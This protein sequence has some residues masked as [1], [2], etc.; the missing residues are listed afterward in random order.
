MNTN[1]VSLLTTVGST[2]LTLT[3]TSA[4]SARGGGALA[5]VNSISVTPGNT[6][7]VVVGSGGVGGIVS[8]QQ[9][10]SGANGACTLRYLSVSESIVNATGLTT[11]RI[12]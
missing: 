3:A 12:V 7:T 5:Y 8:G 9:A 11:F 4:G 6:Y 2:S 10:A 1:F